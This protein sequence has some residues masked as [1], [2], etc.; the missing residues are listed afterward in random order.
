MAVGAFAA[1]NF[2]LRV[3]AC[4]S[5]PPSSSAACARR[6]WASPS[7]CPACASSGFYLAVATL[8]AQ[9]FIVWA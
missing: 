2:M 6:R 1:Y 5:W 4:R 8:A 3:P 9:F 7:A